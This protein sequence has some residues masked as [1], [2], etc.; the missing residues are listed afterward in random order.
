[1]L[2]CR[3]LSNAGCKSMSSDGQLTIIYWS[4]CIPEYLNEIQN[5]E[6]YS[7]GFGFQHC[8]KTDMTATKVLFSSNGHGSDAHK[9][10]MSQFICTRK[11]VS[12]IKT[13]SVPR[14]QYRSY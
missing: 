2:V 8:S 1:V 13:S 5:T 12:C 4:T 14:S 10:I 6:S 3:K 9:R 11:L 7:E